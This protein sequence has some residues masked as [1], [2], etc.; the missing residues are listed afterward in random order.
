MKA[1]TYLILMAAAILVPA[2][3]VAS[4]GLS[5]LLDSERESRIR[6]VQE[7]GR[8]TA[9]LIDRE[10]AVA[11]ASLRGIV[12]SEALRRGDFAQLHR[13]AS[14]MNAATPWSWTLLMHRSG[15]PMLNTL[16]PWGAPLPVFSAKWVGEVY[17][18]QNTRV[19]GYFFGTLAHRPTISVDV[20]VPRRFGEPYVVSQI[21]DASYFA[22][23]FRDPAI[24]P[25]WVITIFDANGIAIA[26]NR[27][28]EEL[29]GKPV[30][31]ELYRASRR[32]PNGIVRHTTLDGIDVYSVYT[33]APLS[34]WTL[35]IGVPAPEIEARARTATVYAALSLLGMMGLATAIAVFLAKRLSMSLDQARTAAQALASGA[36]PPCAPTRVAEV[37]MLLDGLRHTSA[38][39]ARERGARQRLQDEREALLRSEHEA[40]RQAEAQSKA[41]D[42]FLAMLGHELRNPLAAIA[43]AIQALDLPDV[44]PELAQ[45]ARAIGRRQV[46]HL[47]RIVDDLLDVRRILSGKVDLRRGRLDAGALLH[48]C[49]ETRTLA[50]AGAHAWQV[51]AASLWID[52][53]PTRLEQIFDNLLHNA[54]K[55]TP[56][57][58]TIAVRAHADGGDAVIEVSD[59]GVGIDADTLPTIFDALVQGP[60]G[61]DR[62]QGGLGLGL[63]LVRELTALHGGSAAAYSAGPDMGS[64]FTLR[65]PLAEAPAQVPG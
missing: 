26:R 34:G 5:R 59:T 54:I 29:V 38:D 1:R 63:A 23:V 27:N 60:T 36:A 47:T 22:R 51:D 33:R 13:E 14:A 40:R 57:G 20:P 25:G 53:D 56:Q 43:G 39:L 18:T 2:A 62:A 55:Y 4:A 65:F 64:T 11:E 6:S 49:C 19:S 24:G 16:V 17:D 44:K 10:I 28:A 46:C 30:R 21:F 37:D 48:R 7:T 41:K 45:H 35:A 50:D 42:S 3:L 52:A 8:A 31:P 9:L 61:I 32:Q 15:K 58:G 12:N